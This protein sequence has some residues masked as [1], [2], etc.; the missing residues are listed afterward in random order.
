MTKEER[1]KVYNKYGGRCA[2]CGREI[3][4]KDM[5]VDHIVPK[6]RNYDN[7]ARKPTTSVVG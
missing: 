5:Q 3:E 1:L 4:Y 7:V 2:Y 6:Q